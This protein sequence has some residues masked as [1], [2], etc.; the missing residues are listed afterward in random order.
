MAVEKTY[1]KEGNTKFIDIKYICNI[2]K[3]RFLDREDA[4]LCFEECLKEKLADYEAD[5]RHVSGISE[6]VVDYERD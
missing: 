2:C 1:D 3:D 4:E 5:L 6:R